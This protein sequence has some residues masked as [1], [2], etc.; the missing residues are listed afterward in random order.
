VEARHEDVLGA[1]QAPDHLGADRD[2]LADLGADR[3]GL[4]ALALNGAGVAPD[5]LLGV[6]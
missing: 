6:L 3:Q 1:G 4:V 2:D 5:A